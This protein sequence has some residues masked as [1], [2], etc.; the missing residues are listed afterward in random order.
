M[1][2]AVQ[3]LDIWSG[4]DAEGWPWPGVTVAPLTGGMQAGSFDPREQVA[5]LVFG[6]LVLGSICW[7]GVFPPRLGE[8]QIKSFDPGVQVTLGE[9]SVEGWPCPGATLP[10][11]NGGVVDGIFVETMLPD[12][13]SE[14]RGLS[15]VEGRVVSGVVPGGVPELPLP[16]G[17]LVKLVVLPWPC[18][19]GVEIPL[20]LILLLPIVGVQLASTPGIHD[21]EPLGTLVESST[22][23]WLGLLGP[24][25]VWLT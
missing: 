4:V 16:I 10:P 9:G 18:P 11:P 12:V 21:F 2:P 13:G 14:P 8:M 15:P 7:E 17:M 19:G 24:G 22:V 20:G 23:P 25:G 1:A 6:V 3:V 5:G